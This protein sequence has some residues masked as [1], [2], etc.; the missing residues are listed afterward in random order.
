MHKP[1]SPRILVCVVFPWL[2]FSLLELE[3]TRPTEIKLQEF[4]RLF[5]F[6]L[7]F[8]MLSF[9]WHHVVSLLTL[10]FTNFIASLY[11]LSCWWSQTKNKVNRSIGSR[12]INWKQEKFEFCYC[13][14]HDLEHM[15]LILKPDL[16]TVV[17]YQHTKNEVNRFKSYHLEIQTQ[18]DRLTDRQTCV[19]PLPN[20][21]RGG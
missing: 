6:R 12:V 18:K 21:S 17:I 15:A 9:N 4:T 7:D 14:D 20:R 13:H 1:L 5:L 3:T 2:L 19:K 16:D 10:I 11:I 8:A